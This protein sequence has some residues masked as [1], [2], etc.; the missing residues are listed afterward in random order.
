MVN[1]IVLLWLAL[2]AVFDL[3]RREVPD[4]LTLPVL[5]GMLVWRVIHPGDW[6]PWAPAAATVILT[7]PGL[8]PGGYMKG[9]AA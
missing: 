6:L 9:L 8:L 3:K 4:R 5:A 2:C 7:L 1:F